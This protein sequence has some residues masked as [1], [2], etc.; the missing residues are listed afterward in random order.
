KQGET[1]KL[2]LFCLLINATDATPFSVDMDETKTIDHVKNAIKAKE[3]ILVKAS[4][5]RLFL[6]RKDDEWLSAT[7]PNVELSKTDEID[8]TW[9]EHELNPT[10]LLEDVFEKD[11]LGKRVIHVL[12]RVPEELEAEMKVNM[13]RKALAIAQASEKALSITKEAKAKLRKV[14]EERRKQEEERRKQEEEQRRIEN[15]PAKRKR[16]WNE[17]NKVLEKKRGRD[18]STGFSSVEYESLPKRFRPSRENEVTEGP[19]FDL[20]HSEVAKTSVDDATLDFVVKVLRTKLLAYKSSEV[21][22]TTRVQFMGAIFENVVCMFDEEDRKRDPEDRTQLHIES[23]MVG[24]YVKANGTVDFRITRG[25]KMVCV[26]EAKDDDFKKGSAQ[27]I[28]G[29]EVAV[30]NNNEECVYGVVTNYSGWR[31]LKRTDEKIEMF[32]DVIGNDNLRDDVKRVSGRLYAML[33]N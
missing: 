33:A 24:Q 23:K 15:M 29:M 19:F 25:T 5:L 21:N 17:L 3:E 4:S 12:V 31:F 1:M 27:S 11:K 9:L 26:I 18:G 16:D 10:E 7:D 20:L 30:D 14:E 13:V 32:R 2:T 22:E 6:A 8:K 28:L